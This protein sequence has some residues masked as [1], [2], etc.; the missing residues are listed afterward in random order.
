ELVDRL[1][2][3]RYGDY[4]RVAM[5]VETPSPGEHV[6]REEVQA[7]PGK[8]FTGDHERKSFYKGRL[9]PGREVTS[10]SLEV[11]QA[12]GVDPIVVGDNLI[13]EGFDLGV[14]EPGDRVEV[15]TVLLERSPQEHRPCTVFRDRTS[16]EAFA[17]ISQQRFRGA[18]FTVVTGGVLQVGELVRTGSG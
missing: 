16:P 5:L 7:V 12:L 17:A 6:S 3:V 15:G 10:V 1:V 2:A 14:L 13:T 8:G 4:A 11:L 9:V 18:V